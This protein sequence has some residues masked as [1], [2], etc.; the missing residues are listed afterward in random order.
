MITNYTLEFDS[1]AEAKDYLDAVHFERF[2]GPAG[3]S[4]VVHGYD[5]DGTPTITFA[6][7]MCSE[8]GESVTW[9]FVEMPKRRSN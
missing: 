8:A 5:D 3:Y 6:R 1:D 2:P 7:R 4:H 9:Y